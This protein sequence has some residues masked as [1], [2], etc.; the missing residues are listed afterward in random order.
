MLGLAY[1]MGSPQRGSDERLPTG[2]AVA[3]GLLTALEARSRKARVELE[4]GQPKLPPR[5]SALP[6]TI[7]LCS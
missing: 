5:Q 6:A 3:G 7:C 4:E 1:K 2:R